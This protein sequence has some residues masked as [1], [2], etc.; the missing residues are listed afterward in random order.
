MAD[1]FFDQFDKV[2]PAPT[3]APAAQTPQQQSA[4]PP[5]GGG[6]AGNYF[7]QFDTSRPK[8]SGPPPPSI[9]DVARAT[10]EGLLT[11]IP[12]AVLDTIGAQERGRKLGVSMP[13]ADL[14][15]G[16]L[17]P[18][19]QPVI[20]KI[21]GRETAP[22]ETPTYDAITKSL[23]DAK[24]H[25]DDFFEMPKTAPE[26]V[27]RLAGE[28]IITAIVPFGNRAKG[29]EKIAQIGKEMVAGGVGGAGAGAAMEVA[30]DEFKP[31]AGLAG[32]LAGGVTGALAAEVPGAA[33]RQ[34]K[35]G[36]EYVAPAIPTKGNVERIAAKQMGETV[37]DRDA[38]LSALSGKAEIIPGSRPTA[39]Q[40][41]GDAGLA[42]L[43]GVLARNDDQFKSRLIAQREQQVQAQLAA[44]DDVQNSGSPSAVADYLNTRMRQLEEQADALQEA[45]ARDARR[46]VDELGPER[47][48]NEVGAQARAAISDQLKELNAEANALWRSIPQDVELVTPPLIRSTAEIYGRMSPEEQLSLTPQE[49]AIAGLIGSYGQT[50]PFGRFKALRSEITKAMRDAKSGMN[51]NN[52]AYGRLSQLR[53]AIEDAVAD[54]VAGK[55]E[56]ENAAVARGVMSEEDTLAAN[57]LRQAKEWYANRGQAG[58][59]I[60]ARDGIPEAGGPAPIPRD[61]GTT[62]QTERGP[63]VAAR[64]QGLPQ[65]VGGTQGV[66]D[67]QGPVG[68]TGVRPVS[69][70][71][72]APEGNAGRRAQVERE[73]D[74]SLRGLPRK[75]GAVTASAYPDAQRVA[76]SYM[77]KAGLPY[78]PPNTYAK[79]NPKRAAR[80]AT[81][82]DQ[83]KHDPQNHEVKAAYDAMARETLAQ[84]DAMLADGM[85]I[86]FIPA[87]S[88]DPYAGNPRNMTEDVRNNKHMW[89]FATRDGFGSD[90]TFD[91]VDNPLL[92]DSGYKISGQPATINDIFRAVHDYFGHVKEGV[93][94][95]ADGEENAWRAHS[96]MYS[97]EARRAMTTETRGQNSWVNYGPY[98][99]KNRTARSEDTHYA[100]QK[101]GLLPDW[102]INE[103]AG[104]EIVSP[105]ADVARR[106]EDAGRPEIEADAN[107]A[108]TEAFYDAMAK[109]LGTTVDELTKQYDLPSV[110]REAP[111]GD[112]LNQ[113]VIKLDA[114]REQK[115]LQAFHNDLLS[116][117]RQRAAEMADMTRQA[118]EKG[119]F[120]EIKVGDRLTSKS[121]AGKP[122]PP[123]KVEALMLRKWRG[124]KMQN[125]MFERMGVKPTIV[126]YSGQQYV[127][128]ARVLQGVEGKGD[129][130]RGDVY[131]DMLRDRKMGDLK[132]VGSNTFYQ[133]MPDE[134]GNAPTF[135]SAVER[136]VTASKNAKANADQWLATIKNTPGVKAEEIEWLGLDPW[137]RSQNGPVTKEAVENFIRANSIQVEE[138]KLRG[139]GLGE[140]GTDLDISIGRRETRDP[141]YDW[142]HEQ[143]DEIAPQ[144][145][146]E[147]MDE[148][149]PDYAKEYGLSEDELRAW[150][151]PPIMHPDLFDGETPMQPLTPEQIEIR[152]ELQ[153]EA[154]KR[155]EKAAYDAMERNYYEEPDEYGS[156]TATLPNG[157]EVDYRVEYYSYGG[158]SIYNATD[159]RDVYEWGGRFDDADIESAIRDDLRE[160]LDEFSSA[161]DDAE[162]DG[163]TK[164]NRYALK[165]GDDYTELLLKLPNVAEGNAAYT[166]SHW[167]EP[168]VVAHVRFD[169]RDIGG[170]KTLFLQEIQSD[171][172]QQGREKGYQTPDNEAKKLEL[173]R[174]KERA[175]EDVRNARNNGADDAEVEALQ[176]KYNDIYREW[177]QASYA[178][179]DA[180]FK[181]T[182]PD[183]VLKRMI[184][185][186]AEN[187]FEQIVWTPGDLQNG[188][189]V[190]REVPSI[191]YAKNDDGSFNVMQSEYHAY[192]AHMT[193]EEVANTYGGKIAEQMTAEVGE[194]KKSSSVGINARTIDTGGMRI[195]N[196]GMQTFYGKIVP[197][198]LS[199]M[200]KKFDT[201]IERQPMNINGENIS[202][203]AV[204]VTE[205]LRKMALEE[206]QPLYQKGKRGAIQFGADGSSL[207]SMLKNADASTAPHE[208]AHHFLRMYQEVAKSGKAPNAIRDDW[209]VVNNW[210]KKN[211]VH[212]AA[213]A[214]MDGVTPADVKRVIDEGTTGDAAKDAAV[215]RGMQEQWARAFEAYLRDGTAPTVG[216]KRVFE[217]FKQW[218]QSIY[219]SITDLGVDMS[220]DIK[221]VFDRM[222]GGEQAEAPAAPTP[223]RPN[224]MTG[225]QRDTFKRATAATRNI[226]D[227][228]T[229]R[230][231]GVVGK[232][233]ERPGNTY[234][235]NVADETVASNLW[236]PGAKGATNIQQV[237]KAAGNAPEAREAIE[238]AALLSIRRSA[239]KEGVI[240]PAK[241]E[242]WRAKHADAL[243]AVPE[244]DKRLASAKKASEAMTE[245][246]QRRKDAM[247]Q[248]EKSA[249]GK[250]LKVD[251]DADVTAA[252]GSLLGSKNSVRAMRE[253]VGTARNNPDA[254]AGLRRAV[255]EHMQSRLTTSK[256][257]ISPAM[258]LRYLGRNHQALAQV[259]TPE[260]I[261]SLRA[262]GQELK[263]FSRD[264]RAP[265]GGSHTAER[266]AADRRHLPEK[267]SLFRKLIVDT[268][269]G[270]GI[271]AALHLF[272]PGSPMLTAASAVASAL[273]SHAI[274]SAREAGLRRVN[275]LIQEALLDPELMKA[276]LAKAPK[277]ANTG[278]HVTLTQRL[279]KIAAVA[280][281]LAQQ[282]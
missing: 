120:G 61:T 234:P 21:T 98:G 185:Y 16:F 34:V 230:S 153:A 229:G 112:A 272:G 116:D 172:H 131:V 257:A 199:K 94:F 164:F 175:S 95:R 117:V 77:K 146:D 236:A 160:I 165:G 38:A 188:S 113:N 110:T 207:I 268:G 3:A 248:V 213:D 270:G 255:V 245:I 251:S 220:P 240:D 4:A 100:D 130:S 218:L 84:Y 210:W 206:G 269:L 6:A 260:Q 54:S 147:A 145:I 12:N 161:S 186:A 99:E 275:D 254:L 97:P 168:N 87:G 75:V 169:T 264:V 126:E 11:G 246:G 89:V 133:S 10:G 158:G 219:R 19:I 221:G 52:L 216:L 194:P 148:L 200:L 40:M 115:K 59:G 141:D 41:T 266:R 155:G 135:Y 57:F 43:E 118:Q 177:T 241:L 243:R 261:N 195:G 265:G 125:A 123:M 72:A 45:A 170:K 197:N 102:V 42:S 47:S 242:Q 278:S 71:P 228:Y 280:A 67:G 231:S 235:Y 201:K 205:K 281:V 139:L 68:R 212:V 111:K 15:A 20:D 203:M 39:A 179:P 271:G 217:Q 80:I 193:A 187:D 256:E 224:L 82:Y 223:P 215:N 128:M 140:D 237:L 63:A 198:A 225:Q 121:A 1:N 176:Q 49:K 103:A 9:G 109:R 157:D 114:V 25:P 173:Y 91:P 167:D 69:G 90:A 247:T 17:Q 137:L 58:E 50:I 174:A 249:I 70:E 142:L 144:Y 208:L 26:R 85:T 192:P 214:E 24:M 149:I 136:A 181:T 28:G 209:R 107:A 143:A 8:P 166:R 81:A 226:K 74:G 86:E 233:L 51:P 156:V 56:Q 191:T 222:L 202:A 258:F 282:E 96:S 180:P 78:R 27:G 244:L 33:I 18:A 267:P 22:V 184:R 276:L 92:A 29:W 60:A 127:P 250:L 162:A 93:G 279:A 64:D 5:Q 263:R 262:L 104:D 101:I 105:R 46:A 66:T 37:A 152:D 163:A 150:L 253:L 138:T 44:L 183:L 62:L 204:P 190:T 83:M 32:G 14:V 154:K 227:T 232:M 23:K 36:A 134:R 129:W 108:L 35:R 7:D 31:L 178:V 196:H 88:A 259:L 53:G 48:A 277:K 132:P 76:E 273:G 274:Q 252:V 30:P 122:L 211:A 2:K 13:G 119:A 124:D 151:G 238:G 189:I 65:D 239:M 106:F 182:W 159:N 73:A 171:W 79:V 55:I